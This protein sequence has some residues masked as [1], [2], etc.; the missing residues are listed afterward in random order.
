MNAHRPPLA[1][2]IGWPIGHSRSP[3]LHGHWLRRYGIDGYYVPIGLA[4][5]D[6]AR[7]LAGLPLLGFRGVNVTIPHKEAA[8]AAASEVTE[9]A[10]RV[11]AANTLTFLPDGGIE[12][13]NTDGYG[14][15]ENLRQG[16]PGWAADRGPAL[17]LGA[18]G[19]SR[20]VVA[21]LLEAGAPE[22]RLANRTR[23]RAERL[24]GDLGGPVRVIDWADISEAADG[25]ALIVNTSALGMVGQPPLDIRLD[26][27]PG[28]ALVTDIVYEPLVTPILA[29]A[30]ARG[31]RVVDGLGMLLHQGVPGFAR[32]FGKTP[33]VDADL[34]EAVLGRR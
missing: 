4:P 32:W 11:G 19:A 14:F 12:A 26:G 25:A 2:V 17:V 30:A 8:L 5:E 22:I 23:A 24:A 34:R 21:A 7:G 6:F 1:G 18:G 31:L 9:R 28:H 27:A 20:A 13:D 3:R 15:L 10:A 33:L 16:A 29:A